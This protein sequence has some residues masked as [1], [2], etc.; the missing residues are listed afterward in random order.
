MLYNDYYQKE[1]ILLHGSLILQMQIEDIPINIP[2]LGD[3]T[4]EMFLSSWLAHD[5]LHIKQITKLKYDYF[6]EVS[7]GK[8]AYAGEWK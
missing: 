8:V 5:Y 2:L 4:A 7:G 3:I 6:K 1:I